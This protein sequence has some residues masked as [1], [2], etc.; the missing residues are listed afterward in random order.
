MKYQCRINCVSSYP[1]LS[2]II[3]RVTSECAGFLRHGLVYETKF[4][5]NKD[6]ANRMSSNKN[7]SNLIY[8]YRLYYGPSAYLN[9]K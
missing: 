9:L 4:T 2:S 6:Q 8:F 7:I 1:R 5:E 3:E